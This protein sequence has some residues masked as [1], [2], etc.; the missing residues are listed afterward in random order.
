LE[1]ARSLAKTF[2]AHNVQL[3]Y[4]GGTVGLMGELARTLVSLSG[5]DAVHGIIPA[6]LVRYEQAGRPVNNT[7]N[8]A[9]RVDGATLTSMP[10]QS[11]YGTT[12]VVDSMHARKH[13]MTQRVLAGG[14]GSGFIAL[15][16]G[17]G[18]IEEVMEVTTWNQLGIHDRGI[19]I[20][21]VE[22]YWDGLIRWIGDSV[23]AGFVGK[24]NEGIIQ[25]RESAEDCVRALKEYRIAGARFD[26][27][28]NEK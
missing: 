2:H 16:G 15:S 6:P 18:T 12:Q 22:G 19:V 13:A 8:S 1:A 14:P 9:T 5:P 26:L 4:G 27:D 10:D 23:K 3:V 17:F 28:W 25:V 7:D 21:N 11:Q 24:G 20:F